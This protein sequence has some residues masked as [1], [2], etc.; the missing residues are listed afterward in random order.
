MGIVIAWI[1]ILILGFWSLG[2]ETRFIKFICRNLLM[3]YLTLKIIG[4]SAFCSL[5]FKVNIALSSI[6]FLILKKYN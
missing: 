1:L 3:L 6:K 5:L 2:S 4:T